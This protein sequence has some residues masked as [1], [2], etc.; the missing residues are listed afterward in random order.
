MNYDP[1]MSLY[2]ER[3]KSNVSSSL[4]SDTPIYR[5]YSRERLGEVIKKKEL[6]L[7]AFRKW[8]DPYEGFLYKVRGVTPTNQII[9]FSNFLESSYGLCWTLLPESDALWRIYSHNKDGVVVRTSVK[10]LFDEVYGDGSSTA[11]SLYLEKVRYADSLEINRI[12][13][14][15]ATHLDAMMHDSSGR[16]PVPFLL[17]K[18]RE[19]EHEQEV[20]LLYSPETNHAHKGRD[21]VPFPIDPNSVFD[22]ILCDPRMKCDEVESLKTELR[23]LGYDNPIVRSSLYDPPDLKP[24]PINL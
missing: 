10:K 5:V 6:T 8:E 22:S 24:V 19:F 12:L 15:A 18:R 3:K 13:Q 20:R 11:L 23:D 1:L 7:S 14:D 2:E 16:G 9:D 21:Y 17:I 4:R